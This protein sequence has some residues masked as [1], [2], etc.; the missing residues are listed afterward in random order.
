[1]TPPSFSVCSLGKMDV[2]G[3]LILVRALR[4]WCYPVKI[5]IVSPM[6]SVAQAVRNR[7]KY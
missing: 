1:M 4:V 3:L 6:S 2:K 7:S 5:Q